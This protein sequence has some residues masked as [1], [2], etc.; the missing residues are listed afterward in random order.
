MTKA[1]VKLLI[2]LRWIYFHINPR[3]IKFCVTHE[4]REYYFYNTKY[5]SIHYQYVW[6]D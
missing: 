5:N 1:I 4:S 2:K 3:Y 6:V